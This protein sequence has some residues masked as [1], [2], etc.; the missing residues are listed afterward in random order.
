MNFFKKVLIFATTQPLE[1]LEIGPEVRLFLKETGLQG[2][3]LHLATQ[4]TTTALMVNERCPELQKDM[5][6]F[7]NRL[8][9]ASM[10]YRHNKVAADGRPN[11]HSHLLSMLFPTQQTLVV[12]ENRL[13]L[14]DWQSIFLVELDGPRPERKVNLTFIGR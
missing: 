5:I 13:E 6:D 2:G 12:S 7:L 11:T 14:G 10:E 8:A 9:P 1:I 3:L 4:H